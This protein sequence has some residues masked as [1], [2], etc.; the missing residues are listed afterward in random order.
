MQ[1]FPYVIIFSEV[2]KLA[3][4]CSVLSCCCV[5]CCCFNCVFGTNINRNYDL[6][7]Y[8]SFSFFIIIIIIKKIYIYIYIIII[9]FLRERNHK[10][11]YKCHVRHVWI[12]LLWLSSFCSPCLI[13]ILAGGVRFL[14][15]EKTAVVLFGT[16]KFCGTTLDSCT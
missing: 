12:L 8:L 11:C 14:P 6:I 15:T 7:L 3:D 1:S 9:S 5:F 4:S 13:S 10:H 16:G 2:N